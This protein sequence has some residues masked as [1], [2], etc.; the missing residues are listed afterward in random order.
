MPEVDCS[1]PIL[2]E[3]TEYEDFTGMTQ[4]LQTIEV[5]ARVS[6]YLA[7]VNFKEGAEVK[8]GDQ[9]FEIDPRPYRAELAQA[10]ANVVQAEAH[11]R[12]LGLDAE[13]AVRL[14]A[15][16]A[17]GREENDKIMGD[18]AEAEAAVG[19]ARASRDRAKLN[20][21]FTQVAAPISGRI[22]RRLLDPWNMVKADETPLTTVVSLDPIYVYFDVDEANVLRQMRRGGNGKPH[23]EANMPVRLG[24]G[25]ED[26]FPHEGTVD[27]IDNQVDMNT[28]TLRMRGVFANAD[29]LL[30]PG[31]FARIRLPIGKPHQAVLVAEQALG[32]DQGK[33]YLYVV[34]K[35][36]KKKEQGKQDEKEEYEDRV[37]YRAVKVGRLY[38]GL[39]EVT[40]GI[41]VIRDPE[42]NVVGEKVIVTGLQ[43]VR[44]GAT[45]VAR[46]VDMPTPTPPPGREGAA[47]KDEQ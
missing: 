14:V 41:K 4:A 1:V 31:L 25:D 17:M 28:G 9:L 8:E 34:Q 27:F 21:D 29:R 35:V 20:L 6:G 26:G 12:R 2:R 15:R 45:V 42:G 7:K 11:A 44:D 36:A 3:V 10:E 37:E 38:D 16:G 13:R 24:L 32:R 23:W 47:Q 22:S 39:R 46:E 40:E 43:R 5:R 30:T 19:S 18:K 33:K